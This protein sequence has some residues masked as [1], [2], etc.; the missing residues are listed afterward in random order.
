MYEWRLELLFKY[1]GNDLN[2]WQNAI[3]SRIQ[4]YDGD[5]GIITYVDNNRF[6]M[7]VHKKDIHINFSG[8][9]VQFSWHELH[10][11]FKD[12]EFSP[13][14]LENLYEYFNSQNCD[15]HLNSRSYKLLEEE[16]QNFEQHE[17]M[18]QRAFDQ[19]TIE[20]IESD[21]LNDDDFLNSDEYERE[22]S[23]FLSSDD[24]LDSAD[25]YRKYLEEEY[26]NHQSI[27]W[28]DGLDDFS[29]DLS[30][31]LSELEK[32]LSELKFSEADD[33]YYHECSEY[34]S[35]EI[36]QNKRNQ[37][38]SSLRQSLF[39]QLE[40]L[41]S[42]FEFHEADSYYHHECSEYISY[43][44]YQNKR[45]Q[46]FQ[47]LKQSLFLQLE[48]LFIQDDYKN[49]DKFYAD[50]CSEYINTE[51][52]HHK[53]KLFWEKKRAS[54]LEELNELFEKDFLVANDFY[55]NHC[56]PFISPVEYQQKKQ[57]FIRSWVQRNN[58]GNKPDLEQ[59]LA[60]GTVNSH[61]QV[62][63]RAG[64]G[65]TSTL[66]NRAIFLQK[67]CGVHPSEILLLVFN[68]KAAQEITDR[69][70]KHLPND[71]PHVM[72]FHALA[73]AIVHPTEKLLFNAP[74]G[75]QDQS[76]ALQSV[77]DD[78][79]RVPNYYEE[80]KT[81]M[82]KRFREDWS[83]IVH[84][85]FDKSPEEVI[86]FRR[87]LTEMGIDGRY[88]KSYGEK[89]IADFLFEHNIQFAY[90]RHVWWDGM[91]Y[92]PDFTIFS[93]TSE[94]KGV[95]IEYFGMKG[96]PDYDEM[97]AKKRRFWQ[98]NFEWD[99]VEL[100]LQIL[101]EEGRESFDNFLKITL[102]EIMRV[103]F[104]RLSDEQI[105]LKIKDRAVDRFTKAMV[106]LMQRS[107]K[108]CLTP[109][110]LS[111]KIDNHQFINSETGEI[112][113]RFLN[114]G[115]AFYKSYLE[116]LEATGEQDFDGL[117]ERASQ[118][119][120]DG[121]T[122]FKRKSE[123]GDLKSLKYIMIDEYQDFSLLFYNLVQAIRNQNSEALFFCVGDD[124]QAI[125]GFAGSDLHYYEKFSQ[126]F[127]PS[128]KLNIPTN[129]RSKT[130]IVEIG[131]KLMEGKGIAAKAST[132]ELGI[133]DVVN[134]A[135][136][137]LSTI[138]KTEYKNDSFTPAI[139][140]LLSKLIKD[141]KEVV[142]ITRKNDFKGKD[143]ESFLSNILKKLKIANTQ[144]KLVTISTAH[145]FKG[146]EG[147]VVILLDTESYPLIHP[148]LLFSRIFGDS[149]DKII[150]E[151]RRLFYVALTR[152]KEHLFIIIDG[153]IVPPFVE[154]LTKKITIPTFNWSMYPSPI[155]E[156]RYITMKIYNQTDTKKGG[157][158]DIK[159]ELKADGY[160]YGSKPSA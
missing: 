135:K 100:D 14:L 41:L 111:Q 117:M 153:G 71:M 7:D 44:V 121:V 3:W 152:A 95:V 57:V 142:L 96:D 84:Q 155:D 31:L 69:L 25:N 91:N 147:Q 157:T 52:Y 1:A 113:W 98:D 8:K 55:Q 132:E 26:F 24:Y 122:Q 106:S 129:Y 73:R 66:V 146:K 75:G 136:F 79:L 107:R 90:E 80:I 150:D 120:N 105:W 32:L 78:Y 46:F 85:G 34:I 118:L 18:E 65:K 23:N 88:Y 133:V 138:E 72:T 53:K 145:Q 104:N 58:L 93:N 10:Y 83:K 112:E 54:L 50:A 38:L 13:I 11:N 45:N 115:Q 87:S 49:A 158:F 134:L 124:W 154:E 109:D 51:E 92:H 42:G 114:L 125:N 67:H 139:L 37:F 140:R 149:I 141:G 63:A 20:R 82:I 101:R 56:F 123:S 36:Y 128:Q 103:E 61:V 143:I 33:Y 81:L 2:K 16:Y 126:I 59:S 39:S 12:I 74:K 21:L 70:K 5:W 127:N 137:N 130:K 119:L 99:F 86:Q 28:E 27:P 156:I 19:K 68:R 151:E 76:R 160:K 94:K 22:L 9:I 60:I 148:D 15:V 108:L 4:T 62:I 144:K 17:Q 47:N 131:N 159:D 97:S 48:D 35:H 30:Y 6:I 64:S 40:K 89:V 116:R 29:Q 110:Q 102:Q 43:E 77:I